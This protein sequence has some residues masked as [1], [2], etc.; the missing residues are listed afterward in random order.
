ME[1]C[2]GCVRI[3]RRGRAALEWELQL[4][5]LVEQIDAYARL[6]SRLEE[7]VTAV[8]LPQMDAAIG[9]APRKSRLSTPLP[10]LTLA[11]RGQLLE[12][13][14]LS[15]RLLLTSTVAE[16]P[17]SCSDYRVWDLQTG[18]L[19][20]IDYFLPPKSAGRYQRWCFQI[21]GQKVW[22]IPKGRIGKKGNGMLIE[23][24]NLQNPLDKSRLSLIQ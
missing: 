10:K 14:W 19:C 1:N 24:G 22:G 5:P 6:S 13:R 2:R 15:V 20:P 8:L 23:A 7:F 3:L 16:H 17:I 18:M 11:C 4:S 12:S 21:D 9:N